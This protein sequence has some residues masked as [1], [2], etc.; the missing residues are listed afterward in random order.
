MDLKQLYKERTVSAEEA[1]LKIPSGSR[2]VLAHAAGVPTAV[3]NSMTA[4]KNRYKDVEIVHLLCLNDAPYTGS[5]CEGH[6]RHNAL[7][8]GGNTRN[9]VSQNKADY[10]PCFFYEVPKLFSSGTM[11][12]DVAIIN[13]SRPDRYGY[14][15]FG[16]SCDYTKPAAQ[17]AKIVIAEVN[18]KMPTVMG[19]N[20]IHISDIDYIVETSKEPAILE[21]A[22][23]GQVE[24]AIGENCAAL[25]EDGS[26]LQL[27]I[28]AIPDAVLLFLKDK[29]DLGIHSEMFSDGVLELVE[30]GVITN[31]NKTIHKGK[32]IAT[33]LMGSKRLYDFVDKNPMV[34]L[35]P[36]DY[37][38]NPLVIMQN[39]KM[40]SINSCLQVDLMGQIASESI[41]LKQF[42]GVGGQV[43]YVRGAS[44]SEDGKSIIAMPSTACDGKVSRIVPFLSQGSAVTTSR[45]DVHYVVTEYGVA[46]LW[47]KTLRKRAESLIEIAHPYFRESLTEEYEKRFS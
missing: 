1:A 17:N 22:E 41:G 47:G 16:V 2:V 43:D 8:V 5:N 28:G 25:I 40:V 21:P 39:R 13:V 44:M 10:T 23:I 31:K 32:M 6:F 26:T 14:C 46:D 35:Y 37:V 4:N 9:A 24:K 12:V 45:N 33:F 30:A 15:S 11:P 27:G 3:V 20:F 36:V 29:N 42:S 7:F 38:N 19:D 18:D 34:E